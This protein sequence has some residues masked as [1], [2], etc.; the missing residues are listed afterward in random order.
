LTFHPGHHRNRAEEH[1]GDNRMK[2]F[3]T[4]GFFSRAAGAALL[5]ATFVTGA[6]AQERWPSQP[7]KI[8]VPYPAGG[9]T[10]LI[11]RQVGEQLGK[12]LGQPVVIEN[13]PGGGTN[14]AS[15]SVVRAKADGYTLLFANNAQ[16]LNNYFGPTPPFE[17]NAL[18][19]VSLVSR[20]AFILAANPRTPF[21]TGAELL[22][23][24][25]AAPGKLTVS[26]AQLDLYVE[27]LNSKAGIKLMHVP[28]KGGA[29]ATTDAISGQVNM[30]FAL[31]P[32][33]QPHIQAGK[34]KAL[35]VTSG[36]RLNSLPDVATLTELG[37]DYD[38]TVWY[39]L[40]APAGTPKAVVDR[41][42]AATQKVLAQPDLAAR[43]RTGGAEPVSSTPE[44]FQ[45][46]L[47]RE[48]T[49][50]QQTAKAMPQLVQK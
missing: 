14:I 30:V 40:M 27:L 42:A 6:L 35:A 29:P 33:L 9:S 32:V 15:E 1:S 50:W 36:K 11:A 43:I 48:G 26:S 39:G 31:V 5:A 46:Q 25:K 7:V 45:A 16:V 12:E 19:P 44:E 21:N 3:Q 37:V 38:I 22:G 24:A 34:L 13:R 20:V 23:A 17:M 28:Y 4:L 8:V 18:E 2:C 47:K 49:F 10:D 41:L